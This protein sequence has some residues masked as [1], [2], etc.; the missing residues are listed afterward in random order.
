MGPGHEASTDIPPVISPASK[1]RIERLIQVG[2]FPFFQILKCS[3]KYTLLPLVC[4]WWGGRASFG[5]QGNHGEI[6]F[7]AFWLLL[8]IFMSLPGGRLPW[9]QLLWPLN[10]YQNETQHD[11]SDLMTIY[12]EIILLFPQF[13]YHIIINFS[14]WSRVVIIPI[15]SGIQRGDFWTSALRAKCWHSWGGDRAD[16]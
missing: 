3:T 9:R 6:K 14:L 4:C 16:Q 11:G 7:H 8:V 12:P 2:V 1:G 5:W 10:H 15:F 13:T